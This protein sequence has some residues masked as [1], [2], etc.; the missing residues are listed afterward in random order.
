MRCSC[1]LSAL[2]ASLRYSLTLSRR[3][4]SSDEVKLPA[5][6]LTIPRRLLLPDALPRT[7]DFR[8]QPVNRLYTVRP[9][10]PARRRRL[11]VF[12]FAVSI[13]Q[14]VRIQR[15]IREH[16]V[17]P[18]LIVVRVNVVGGHVEALIQRMIFGRVPVD[19]LT[20][21]TSTCRGTLIAE[22]NVGCRRN[23][24]RRWLVCGFSVA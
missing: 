14:L 8:R 13:L 3:N 1:V 24:A 11:V 9:M 21:A 23:D 20:F 12:M 2:A 22:S 16:V 10:M 6:Q 4:Q 7:G 15:R 19:S 5:N 17:N 18:R